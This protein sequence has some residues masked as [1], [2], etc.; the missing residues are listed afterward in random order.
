MI[1]ADD[2]K[3]NR[4]DHIKKYLEEKYRSF[5]HISREA[6]SEELLISEAKAKKLTEWKFI[7]KKEFIKIIV[8]ELE[9]TE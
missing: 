7:P 8:D 3:G 4:M 1:S 9:K 2:Q 6:L 5:K